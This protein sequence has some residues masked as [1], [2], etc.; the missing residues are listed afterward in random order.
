ML[1]RDHTA[2]PATHTFIHKCNEP[3]LS[4]LPSR[5]VGAYRLW[6]VLIFRPVKG[7][8]LSWAG[9]LGE[10]LRWFIR[11]RRSPIPVLTGPTWSNFVDTPNDV[12]AIR[13]AKPLFYRSLRHCRAGDFTFVFGDGSAL[14]RYDMPFVHALSR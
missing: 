6:L 8:R 7:T 2:L 13:H 11:R 4:L 9:W 14:W 1:T 12:T 3:Y 10:T 5:R